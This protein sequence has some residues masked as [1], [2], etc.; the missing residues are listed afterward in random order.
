MGALTSGKP[1]Q[2][3]KQ[4]AVQL[5]NDVGNML[6]KAVENALKQAPFGLLLDSLGGLGGS[7]L[8]GLGSGLF[9]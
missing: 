5:A 7:I 4:F 1:K 6:L 2:A 3:I 9:S 8:G